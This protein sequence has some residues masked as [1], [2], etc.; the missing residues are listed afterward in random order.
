MP[1]AVGT[2]SANPYLN[3]RQRAIYNNASTYEDPLKSTPDILESLNFTPMTNNV[4]PLVP[5]GRPHERESEHSAMWEM[6]C[7]PP[8]DYDSRDDDGRRRRRPKLVNLFDLLSTL[9]KHRTLIPSHTVYSINMERLL[10]RLH[11]EGRD[12]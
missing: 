1:Y 4:D 10:C 7:A 11:H 6:A 2:T 8:D 3:N 9:K 5:A 12:D